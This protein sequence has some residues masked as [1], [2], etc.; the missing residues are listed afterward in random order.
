[1]TLFKRPQLRI[2]IDGSR[3]VVVDHN[4]IHADA[5]IEIRDA[6]SV[7]IGG[8]KADESPWWKKPLGIFTLSVAASV[9]AALVIIGIKIYFGW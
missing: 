3:H 1:M 8:N 7:E 4:T 9:T 2:L 6:E 5:Q